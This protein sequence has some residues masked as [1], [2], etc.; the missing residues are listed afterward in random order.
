MLAA[1][2]CPTL[3]N[4]MDCS[5]PGSSVHEIFQARILEWVA[6]SLSRRSSQP[7]NQTWISCTAG[8]PFTIY[9]LVNRCLSRVLQEVQSVNQAASI[10]QTPSIYRMLD[11]A[12]GPRSI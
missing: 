10:S 11:S 4:P 6:V 9:L 3:Y 1:Q 5:P 8:I 12:L 7:R 2:S